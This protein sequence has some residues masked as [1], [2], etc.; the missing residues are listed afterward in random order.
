M[1]SEWYRESATAARK[2][3][4]E[5]GSQA[6]HYGVPAVLTACQYVALLCD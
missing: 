6:R 4:R 2:G 1:N 3:S 5:R